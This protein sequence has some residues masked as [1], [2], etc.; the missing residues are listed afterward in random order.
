MSRPLASATALLLFAA[1]CRLEL[2]SP[3]KRP[4]RD[5]FRAI[6]VSSDGGRS[7]IAARPGL[8]RLETGPLV[9]ILDLRAGRT[10]L[11]RTDRKL[12]FEGPT[13]PRDE[14]APDYDLAPPFDPKLRLPGRQV[15]DLGDDVQA[16]HVCTL[17]RFWTSRTDSIVYW[18]AKDLD[19]LVVRTQWQRLVAGEQ[20]DVRMEELVGVQPGADP[21]LFRAPEGYRRAASRDQILKP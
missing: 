1:S 12:F 15:T 10:T 7:P 3:P 8:R 20:T 13:L 6:L 9:S 11:L 14:I 17:Y 16:G 2:F 21:G 5:G 18:A 4:A 19:R